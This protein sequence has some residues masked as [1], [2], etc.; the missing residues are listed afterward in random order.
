MIPDLELKREALLTRLCDYNYSCTF[1]RARNM[2]HSKTREWLF[3]GS[4]YTKWVSGNESSILWGYSIRESRSFLISMV[5]LLTASVAGAGKTVLA[6]AV[7]EDLF[8]QPRAVDVSLS[9][10]FCDFSN[11]R[12]LKTETILGSWAKQIL[13]SYGDI[14]SAIERKIQNILDGHFHSPSTDDLFLILILVLGL[15]K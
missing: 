12:S 9:Y 15:L 2:R 3:S 5:P 6:S 11:K 4:E 13:I 10:F 14:P 8:Q 7:V 1:S